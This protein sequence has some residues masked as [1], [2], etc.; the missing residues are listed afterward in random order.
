[1]S[2]NQIWP[3]SALQ[4]LT[5][6]WWWQKQTTDGERRQKKWRDSGEASPWECDM[7][8]CECRSPVFI[9]SENPRVKRFKLSWAQTVCVFCGTSMHTCR[10]VG[11]GSKNTKPGFYAPGVI[12]PFSSRITSTAWDKKHLNKT[13]GL[14][15]QR[16]KFASCI[17]WQLQRPNVEL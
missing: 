17:L 16:T 3:T 6:T 2:F 1:M 7:C 11:D 4:T 15:L 8:P 5:A 12:S 13:Q 10:R 9:P 14:F